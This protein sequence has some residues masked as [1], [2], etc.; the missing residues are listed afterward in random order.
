MIEK[1]FKVLEK[2]EKLFVLIQALMII[3]YILDKVNISEWVTF[4]PMLLYISVLFITFTVGLVHSKF[5]S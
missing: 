2:F 3:L 5:F 1:T 4:L